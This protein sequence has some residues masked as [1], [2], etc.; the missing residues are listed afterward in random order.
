MTNI[1]FIKDKNKNYISL[2]VSGHTGFAE[3]GQDILC[4]SISSIACSLALG[5]TKVLK[6]KAK[7]VK[8][9]DEGFLKILMPSNLNQTQFDKSNV[10]FETAMVSFLD[11]IKGYKE[12]IKLEEVCDDVY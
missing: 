8:K 1:K 6:I 2:I 3:Y 11:L 5:L 10:L 4:A 9:D 12:Y 7:I